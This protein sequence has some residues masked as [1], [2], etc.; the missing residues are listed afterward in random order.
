MVCMDHRFAVKNSSAI[1]DVS[2]QKIK[3][4]QEKNWFKVAKYDYSYTF[5]SADLCESVAL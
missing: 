5:F 3:I 1:F 2:N 4:Q